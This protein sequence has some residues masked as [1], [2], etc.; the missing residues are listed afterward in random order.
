[1]TAEALMELTRSH[2]SY[3][4]SICAHGSGGDEPPEGRNQT[5]AA[6][7]QIPAEG[8]MHVTRG[9]ACESAYHAVTLQE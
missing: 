3:P 1:L 9:C 7:V 8:V 4:R 2:V 6:M 5:V